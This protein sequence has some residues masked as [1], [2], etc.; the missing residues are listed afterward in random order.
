MITDG[1]RLCRAYYKARSQ[2]DEA[3]CDVIYFAERDYFDHMAAAA[4]A[5][6]GSEQETGPAVRNPIAV[7]LP[8]ASGR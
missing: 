7:A 2:L 3:E 5:A 8:E 6:F 4:R 1:K